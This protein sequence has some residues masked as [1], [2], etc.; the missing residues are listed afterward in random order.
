[1]NGGA[2]PGERERSTH[3]KGCLIVCVLRYLLYHI[4]FL[5]AQQNYMQNRP[6]KNR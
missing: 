6:V 4:F 5:C 3:R 2:Q 1:M